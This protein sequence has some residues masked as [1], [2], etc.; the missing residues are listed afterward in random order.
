MET[1]LVIWAN[2]RINLKTA[3]DKKKKG[4]RKA[5]NKAGKVNA[6][7]EES[8]LVYRQL[9]RDYNQ[10][11]VDL[12]EE[13]KK[14]FFEEANSIPSYARIHKLLAKDSTSHVGSLLM[15]NGMYTTDSK[16]TAQ[17]LLETHFPGSVQKVGNEPVTPCSQPSRKDWSFAERFT[18]KGRVKWAIHKFYSFKS[19]AWMESFQLCLK[20]A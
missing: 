12:I 19:P 16:E 11:Q 1:Q 8:K 10:A 9:L 4:L 17:H 6:Q 7:Q 15:P 20:K 2:N 5:W 13:S 14:K 18:K 3:L